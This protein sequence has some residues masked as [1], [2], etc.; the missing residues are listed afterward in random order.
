MIIGLIR[1]GET[2]WN[3]I[4]R[5]QGQT[6]IPL[7]ETGL[8]QAKKVALRIL[9]DE[10]KWDYVV[11]SDLQ[12]AK[13]TGEVIANKLNIPLLTPD[14]RLR[15]RGFGQIEGTTKEE[16]VAK[17]GDEFDWIEYGAETF[18]ALQ[19][20]SISFLDELYEKYP[21]GNILCVTHGGLIARILLHLFEGI[22]DKRVGNVSL[23]II[24]YTPQ[25]RTLL[26][27]N[28]MKHN[29]D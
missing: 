2:D 25:L 27:H 29:V 18:E 1:H 28:C 7:N 12:R 3:L 16:R 5:I 23:S 4:G 19:A 8:K 24:N 6:D 15:E 13:Q 20:R 10:E 26:L 22:E 11:T 14:A 21:N 17:W 9:A